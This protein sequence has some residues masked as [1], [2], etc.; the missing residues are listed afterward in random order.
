MP[1]LEFGKK[2]AIRS[3]SRVQNVG[4]MHGAHIWD[5]NHGAA[6]TFPAAAVRIEMT[7]GAAFMF[8]RDEATVLADTIL[9]CLR[10]G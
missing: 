8:S 4:T 6:C 10:D 5:D 1:G 3:V 7:S 2:G 9:D